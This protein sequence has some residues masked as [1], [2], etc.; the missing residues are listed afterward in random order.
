MNREETLELIQ[1]RYDLDYSKKS[2][3]F[4]PGG[5]RESGLA[6]LFRDLGFTKGAEIGVLQG[7][8]SKV[9]L[10]T[11]P[12]LE[13]LGVDAWTFYHT[14]HDFR[15]QKQLDEFK[16]DSK[17]VYDQYPKARMM[18]AW[19]MDAVKTVEDNSLDFVFIDGN[20]AFEYV[21]NDIAEWSK[22][23]RPGGI[24]SGHDFFRPKHTDNL[25]HVQDVV[26]GWTYSH[27]INPWFVFKGDRGPS[28][29]YVKEKD[30]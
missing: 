27:K 2:P 22:K 18:Q 8:Y 14:Y 12:D 28:W 9:L 5:R 26:E 16:A 11:I 13:L 15:R 24:V 25:M 30:L 1:K 23:V 7:A 6:G 21:A 17:K 3:F 20:H 29:F 10:D 4:L 19:S